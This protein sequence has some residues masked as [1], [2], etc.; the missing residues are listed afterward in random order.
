MNQKSKGNQSEGVLSS[1]ILSQVWSS[2]T[3]GRNFD[4]W[5]A[6][7]INTPNTTVY[8]KAIDSVYLES[9]VGGSSLHHLVDGQHDLIGAF[10]AAKTA[11]PDDSLHQEILGTAQHLTKDVFSVSGLPFLSI[12][13]DAYQVSSHWVRDHL[14]IPLRWQGDLL[15]VNAMELLGGS[16]SAVGMVL[17][18]KKK[19]LQ[20][21]GEVAASS[22]LIGILS[23]NPL[24]MVTAIV[25]LGFGVRYHRKGGSGSIVHGA[26]QGG[27]A[28]GTVLAVNSVLGPVV[29][30][31]LAPAIFT[32]SVSLAVGILV[33]RFISR[34]LDR[35]TIDSEQEDLVNW[36]ESV[37]G[38]R[39]QAWARMD[40]S[41]AK[42]VAAALSRA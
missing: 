2:S 19:D 34:K 28:S 3:S 7:L 4:R 23:A 38:L 13:P 16:I 11:L 32:L 36:E 20:I 5:L 24:C 27:V 15:Q 17:G 22:G 21:L 9:H 6:D 31:G 30:V 14:G 37:E 12:S 35:C 40:P 8:D 39:N 26:L 1:A 25:S 29:G 33:R 10:E 18:L 42:L 41:A